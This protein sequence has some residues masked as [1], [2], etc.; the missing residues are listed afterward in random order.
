MEAVCQN[1]CEQTALLVQK[2]KPAQAWLT[3]KTI[4]ALWAASATK[5]ASGNSGESLR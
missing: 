3:L 2:F 5:E 1:P 4:R